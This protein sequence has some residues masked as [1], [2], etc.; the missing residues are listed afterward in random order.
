MPPGRENDV[1]RFDRW[2]ASYDQSNLQRWYFEPVHAAMLDL[3]E[4]VEP[5]KCAASILDIG[6]GTGRLLGAISARWPSARLFG[7]DPAERMILEAA[8]LNRGGEFHIAQAEALPLPSHSMDL[9]LSSI[10]FHHWAD[11]SKGLREIRRVLRPGGLF[12]LADHTLWLGRLFNERIRGRG[13]LHALMD[14]A[15]L[16]VRAQH[17]MWLQFVLLTLV[18]SP[19][20]TG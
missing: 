10:S 12:A 13:T 20:S 9:V 19:E 11:Q 15:G 7:V 5:V 3:I 17:R 14:A 2:A 1:E 6:C 4:R 16:A 18:V 8:R